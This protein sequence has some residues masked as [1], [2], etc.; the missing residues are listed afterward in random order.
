CICVIPERVAVDKRAQLAQ[1]GAEVHI[2]K[3]GGIKS[4]DNFRNVAARLA[5]E[6]GWFLANQFHNAANLD[7]HFGGKGFSA[8]GPEIVAQMA[9]PIG[10][11]VC[12]AGTG[13]TITGIGHY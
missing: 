2:A 13:G 10:A 5:E 12:S 7:A 9:G 11:F 1:L 4:P 6:N 8:T 3:P